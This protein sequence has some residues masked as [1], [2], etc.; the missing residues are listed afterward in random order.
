L[1]DVSRYADYHLGSPGMNNDAL[2]HSSGTKLCLYRI[3]NRRDKWIT[4]SGLTKIIF[5]FGRETIDP[6][7]HIQV[8]IQCCISSMYIT[9]TLITSPV[10]PITIKPVSEIMQHLLVSFGTHTLKNCNVSKRSAKDCYRNRVGQV[11][12][13]KHVTFIH[14]AVCLIHMLYCR[15]QLII[16]RKIIHRLS[17]DDPITMGSK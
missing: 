14:C 3:L 12:T 7:L 13:R 4:R 17:C 5:M 1:A 11:Y 10:G 16:Q 6:L 9:S 2:L 8:S 15:K